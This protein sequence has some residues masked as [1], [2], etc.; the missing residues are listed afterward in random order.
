MLT[1]HS[2]CM[3]VCRYGMIGRLWL[4]WSVMTFAG[5]FTCLMGIAG[6]SFGMTIAFVVLVGSGIGVSDIGLTAHP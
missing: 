4:L 3:G 1:C 5:L 6:D 2:V